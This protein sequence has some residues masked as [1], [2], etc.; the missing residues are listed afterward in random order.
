MISEI[1]LNSPL[2][3]SIFNKIVKG[4]TIGTAVTAAVALRFRNKHMSLIHHVVSQIVDHGG[5]TDEVHI[6]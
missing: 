5:A 4:S 2:M 6:H 3:Y 1:R